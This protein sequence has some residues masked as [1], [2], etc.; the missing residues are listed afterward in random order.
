MS[1]AQV[2]AMS[3]TFGTVT[4]RMADRAPDAV[5]LD[6]LEQFGEA[7]SEGDLPFTGYRNAQPGGIRRKGAMPPLRSARLRK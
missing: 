4:G 6:A 2:D 7:L 1:A 3:E 5:L